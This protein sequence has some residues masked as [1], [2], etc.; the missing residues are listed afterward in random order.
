MNDATRLGS[1]RVNVIDS[2]IVQPA[3]R[4]NRMLSLSFIST[5]GSQATCNKYR[6]P[7]RAVKCIVSKATALKYLYSKYNLYTVNVLSEFLVI[8]YKKPWHEIQ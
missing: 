1:A 2:E 5:L 4:M 3:V 8:V 6:C 7:R